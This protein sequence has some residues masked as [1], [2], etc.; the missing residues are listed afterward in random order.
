MCNRLQS[1]ITYNDYVKFFKKIYKHTKS[2]KY[3]INARDRNRRT[4]LHVA[5]IQNNI[6]ATQHLVKICP[7][8]NIDAKDHYG[9]RPVDYARYYK[10]RVI[11]IALRKEHLKRH[12]RRN[13]HKRHK[14][15]SV[16]KKQSS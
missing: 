10:Y 9:M 5:V 13:Q 11:A 8:I 7:N 1:A 14:K 16:R 4:P 12:K 2:N 6:A 15:N 3:I